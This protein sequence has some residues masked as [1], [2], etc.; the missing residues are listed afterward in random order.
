VVGMTQLNGNVYTVASKGATTFA[1]SGVDGTGYSA[2]ASGGTY[3]RVEN[4]FAGL[5]HLNEQT[6]AICG[7]GADLGTKVVSDGAISALSNYYNKV[8]I[9]LPFTSVVS[10]MPIEASTT[11]GVSQGKTKRIHKASV[12]F[13]NT[14][15]GK[16]G[17]DEDHLEVMSFGVDLYTGD[18]E[19]ELPS[20]YNTYVTLVILQ[21]KPLP[22]TV[23]SVVPKM[24]IYGT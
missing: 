15:G 4:T 8:H 12:R 7:D 23:L 9:G 20:D 16:V 6:V 22:M 19:Q 24:G 13:L 11:Q 5:T 14:I 3:Q 18:K 17:P 10:P 1:L 2:Y 21:D